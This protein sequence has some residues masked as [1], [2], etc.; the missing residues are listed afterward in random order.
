M[1]QVESIKDKQTEES[2]PEPEPELDSSFAEVVDPED[3]KEEYEDKE[4]F[5]NEMHAWAQKKSYDWPEVN[6]I[7]TK[8]LEKVREQHNGTVPWTKMLQPSW[9]ER[10]KE[11][12]EQEYLSRQL[13]PLPPHYEQQ[14][15]E[16]DFEGQKGEEE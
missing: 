8:L 11:R 5:Y 16:F 3:L 13:P 6:E 14:G 1:D 9:I 2:E 15:L 7:I 12:V 10:M 4:R